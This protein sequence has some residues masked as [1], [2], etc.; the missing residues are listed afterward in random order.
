[1]TSKPE[2]A[3]SGFVVHSSSPSMPVIFRAPSLRTILHLWIV[4]T[5]LSSL[6]QHLHSRK[7][8]VRPP[9][10][11]DPCPPRAAS[12][13]VLSVTAPPIGQPRTCHHL[14]RECGKTCGSAM[15]G[16]LF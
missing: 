13:R 5:L 4:F 15:V 3:T 10:A 12:R 14:P 16:A 7:R 1:R 8:T 11:V 6:M 9:P 2:T